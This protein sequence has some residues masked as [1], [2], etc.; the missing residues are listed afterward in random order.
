[1]QKWEKGKKNPINWEL[2]FLIEGDFI[3]GLAVNDTHGFSVPQMWICRKMWCFPSHH[4]MSTTTTYSSLP[5]QTSSSPKPILVRTT[6]RASLSCNPLDLHWHLQLQLTDIQ[7]QRYIIDS[8]KTQVAPYLKIS[9]CQSLS[10]SFILHCMVDFLGESSGRKG[11]K[12]RTWECQ[13]SL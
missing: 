2:Y 13:L 1:M 6:V 5:G 3:F 10:Q 9:S 8:P 7:M 11:G 4:I 12:D